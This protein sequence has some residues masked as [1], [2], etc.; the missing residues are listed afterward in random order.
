MA[1]HWGLPIQV[2]RDPATGAGYVITP[3]VY[4]WHARVAGQWL[5]MP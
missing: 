5:M 4:A 1:H 2:E 3:S